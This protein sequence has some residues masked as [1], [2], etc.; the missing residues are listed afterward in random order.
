MQPM[1]DRN[2]ESLVAVSLKGNSMMGIKSR[3]LLPCRLHGLQNKLKQHLTMNK[4]TE[5]GL[6]FK[7]C[8]LEQFFLFSCYDFLRLLMATT[9]RHEITNL[10]TKFEK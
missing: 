9:W 2:R 8:V 7:A 3:E 4:T 5:T 10:K 6:S 1:L